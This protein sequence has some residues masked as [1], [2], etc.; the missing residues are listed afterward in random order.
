M[1]LLAVIPSA[2]SGRP[3]WQFAKICL[4]CKRPM[5][6]QRLCKSDILTQDH[7]T[8]NEENNWCKILSP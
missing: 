5:L 7:Y 4:Q 6:N 1:K 2:D 3:S 8:T